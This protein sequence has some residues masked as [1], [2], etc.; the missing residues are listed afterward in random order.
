MARISRYPRLANGTTA[1]Q[2]EATIV[3]AQFMIRIYAE[4]LAMDETIMERIRQLIARQQ[5]DAGDPEDNIRNLRLVLV[6]LEK[7]GERI[8]FWNS[9][10]RA[11]VEKRLAL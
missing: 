3:Q 8:A 2:A 5:P 4:I 11:L 7:V 6:Q 10:V 1:S 9:R